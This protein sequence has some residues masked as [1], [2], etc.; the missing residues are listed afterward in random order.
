MVVVV[1]VVVVMVVVV[2]L[3]WMFR[4]RSTLVQIGGKTAGEYDL[5]YS[6]T[7]GEDD[8]LSEEKSRHRRH[9]RQKH[10]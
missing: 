7:E 3:V 1:V 9:T 4:M 6:L 8:V 5:G 10:S 2:G